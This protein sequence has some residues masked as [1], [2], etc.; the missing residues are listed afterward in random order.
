MCTGAL[1]WWEI[2]RT[3][4]EKESWNRLSSLERGRGLY[5]ILDHSHCSVKEALVGE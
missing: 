3:E 2:K 1:K 5:H 4:T